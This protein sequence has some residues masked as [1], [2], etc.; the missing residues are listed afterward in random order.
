MILTVALM[1]VTQMQHTTETEGSL[2]LL[3]VKKCGQICHNFS[4]SMKR[5]T[6]QAEKLTKPN[7]LT[8][9]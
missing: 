1:Y 3:K 6:N 8:N 2:L 5:Q 7:L 9:F 4:D